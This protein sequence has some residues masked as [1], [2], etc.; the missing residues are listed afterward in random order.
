MTTILLWAGKY[1]LAITIMASPYLL[2]LLEQ[3]LFKPKGGEGLMSV[4]WVFLFVTIP[5]GLLMLAYFFVQHSLLIYNALQ[6]KNLTT[7]EITAH[8]LLIL[9]ILIVVGG[10]LINS[11]IP[12]NSLLRYK[13]DDVTATGKDGLPLIF[14]TIGTGV[15]AVKKLLDNGHDI[16]ARGYHKQTPLIAAAFMNQWEVVAFLIEAGANIEA[17]STFK[18]VN[19]DSLLGI[20]RT[21][22][23]EKLNPE[24]R[25]QFERV[26][27]LLQDRGYT[28]ELE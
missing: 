15:P 14:Q 12:Y 10:Y 18:A 19:K 6:T 2:A 8:L 22:D 20:V 28:T 27:K 23:P 17:T 26:K 13:T 4:G 1:I 24:T 3:A 25:T 5:V 11:T 7:G 21:T 16:E 9:S